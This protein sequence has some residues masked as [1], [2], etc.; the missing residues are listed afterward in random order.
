MKV[1]EFAIQIAKLTAVEI[2]LAHKN[3]LLSYVSEHITELNDTGNV[4]S[5]LFEMYLNNL[6]L[7]PKEVT[8]VML[9]THYHLIVNQKLSSPT[10]GI[11]FDVSPI[12]DGEKYFDPVYIT[13]VMNTLNTITEAGM[14]FKL[15]ICD[16]F[17]D[18]GEVVWFNPYVDEKEMSVKWGYNDY[19]VR[20]LETTKQM[21]SMGKR[22]FINY[23][24][25]ST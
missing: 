2:T 16:G 20:N 22:A 21:C 24:T 13:H 12:L 1:Q 8:A 15:R 17:H 11:V 9:S 7:P 19:T 23:V 6:I 5:K 4:L 18:D 10:G 3:K 14:K 25:T